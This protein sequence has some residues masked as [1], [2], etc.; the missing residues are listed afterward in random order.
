MNQMNISLL[1]MNAVQVRLWH[2]RRANKS[3]VIARDP[4]TRL[5]LILSLSKDACLP[6]PLREREGPTRVSAWEGE[7]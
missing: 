1:F 6:L 7:G 5:A 2:A 3:A 4:L